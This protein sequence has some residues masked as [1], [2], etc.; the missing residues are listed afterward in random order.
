MADILEC[1]HKDLKEIRKYLIKIGPE[2][3][4]GNISVLKLAAAN[5]LY[6]QYTSLISKIQTD[7]KKGNIDDKSVE[8][9]NR[10]SS[11]FLCLY[12]EI[13]D[14]CSKDKER[15][16]TMNS[17]TY[18]DLKIALNLLPVM[19]DDDDVTKKLIENIEYYDSILDK[20][21]CKKKLILF[22]LKSRL[23]QNAKLKLSSDYSSIEGLIKDMRQLLL[24]RKS[25]TALQTKLQRATQKN[26]SV[27]DFGKEITELF[28]ELTISQAEG[29]STKYNVLKPINEKYAIKRFADGLGNDRLSTIIAARNFTSLKDAVQ[30][31]QDE[32][33]STSADSTEVL[34]M[35]Q[36][37]A[38]TS[39]KTPN[40]FYR[41]R[42]RNSR[43]RGYYSRNY[44]RGQSTH[45]SQYNNNNSGSN[46]RP[47]RRGNYTG[48][49]G[50]VS[51]N[52]GRAGA[53]GAHVIEA[54]A[55]REPAESEG[56]VVTESL[57]HFFRS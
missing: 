40:R 8:V 35:Y 20:S 32:E 2:R 21:E 5:S 29:D 50:Q 42:G 17:E 24:P 44:W 51:S 3:R 36:D 38:N 43:Q 23:S 46:T 11:E 31:A 52:R 37:K 16:I 47:N 15:T 30:A 1:L 19:N 7:I 39:E 41:G 12:N 49:R 4:Q 25:P 56:Q 14:L 28:V 22:V 18:F 6:S 33:V 13:I 10:Y 26:K 55:D 34:G 54:E 27:A 45:S 9:I 57:N 48:S 53:E